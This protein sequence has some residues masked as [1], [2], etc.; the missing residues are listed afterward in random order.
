MR[1]AQAR[2]AATF[3]MAA[4]MHREG[5]LDQAEDGYRRVLAHD[6]SNA[7]AL[8]MLGLVHHARGE[9]DAAVSLMRASLAIRETAA[10]RYNLGLVLESRGDVVGAIAAY[11]QAAT[12]DP[13]DVTN[14]SSAIFAGDLHPF[15]TPEIRLA[16]RRAFNARHCA[17][18]TASARMHANTPDPGRRLRVGYLSA[19][20]VDHSAGLVFEP[21]LSGHNRENVEVYLY[22]QQRQQADTI[23]ERFRG[24]ADHWRIVNTLSDEQLAAQIR[25]DGI[26][27]LVDLSGYSNG[28][29]LLALARKPAPVIMTGW[30]HVTGLGIDASDYILAD[31]VAVPDGA[32]WQHHERVL[33]LPNVLAFNPRPPYPDVAAPPCE[34]NGYVTFGY[35]GRA[36][37]MSESVWAA[38]ADVLH[39]VPNSRLVL[40]GREYADAGYRARIAEFFASLR[41]NGSRI[42]FCGAS[43]RQPHLNTY[44]DIDV[45]LDPFPHGGGVT[46]LEACLMGVPTV[47]LLGDHLNGRIG[48][49]V[50]ATLGRQQ[51]VGLSVDHYIEIAVALGLSR[52]TQETRASL[53]DD[54]LRSVICDAQGYAQAVERLYREAWA[55]WC[56][57]RAPVLVGA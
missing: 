45:A 50:L 33:R 49:S 15:S 25:A 4:A 35:L 1:F 54:L 56:V 2:A 11:R 12:L 38:W 7:D 5:R 31:A 28:N 40:K 52:Q 41:I 17:M 8:N 14:W 22:W 19:D 26:D 42:A 46:V 53:R 37:K 30:G 20:F 23:T 47:T 32:E 36:T 27:V 29:R 24:Y 16:D 6:P 3:E 21:V 51:W 57:E 18:L 48:A 34:R 9:G 55:A 39:R 44:A 10:Y 13:D 43:D